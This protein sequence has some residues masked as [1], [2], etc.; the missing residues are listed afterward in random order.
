[1]RSVRLE[2]CMIDQMAIRGEVFEVVLLTVV[3]SLVIYVLVE[4][5]D[6]EYLFMTATAAGSV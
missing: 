6:T 1:M 2:Q 3:V 4:Q 5:L